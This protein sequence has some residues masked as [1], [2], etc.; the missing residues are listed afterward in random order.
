MDFLTNIQPSRH[1][2]HQISVIIIPTIDTWSYNIVRLYLIKTTWS[3]Q[4]KHRIHITNTK[5]N[6][7]QKRYKPCRQCSCKHV[8]VGERIGLGDCRRRSLLVMIDFY[9]INSKLTR[10]KGKSTESCVDGRVIVGWLFS[11]TCYSSS[12]SSLIC[13]SYCY[14]CY[15]MMTICCYSCSCLNWPSYL[16]WD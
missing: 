10:R 5:Q 6:N 4:T 8:V 1:P 14:S 11:F 7:T 15:W 3:Y 9:S 13:C 12:S 16:N 2:K